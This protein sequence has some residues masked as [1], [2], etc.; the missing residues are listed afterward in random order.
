VKIK[1]IPRL[2]CPVEWSKRSTEEP[3]VSYLL[4]KVITVS[5]IP[6]RSNISFP[7]EN[8]ELWMEVIGM[9]S[10]PKIPHSKKQFVRGGT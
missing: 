9:E 4:T 7:F 5:K 1:E 6:S 10:A 8:S 2:P 3:L